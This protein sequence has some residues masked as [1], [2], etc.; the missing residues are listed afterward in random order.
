[1]RPPHRQARLD[2]RAPEAMH[3]EDLPPEIRAAV[4]EELGR[5]LRHVARQ[6]ARAPEP[7]HDR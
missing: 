1:M 7:R 4:R 5:L 3:W 6:V 2:W